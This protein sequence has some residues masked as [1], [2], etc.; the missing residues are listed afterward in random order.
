MRKRYL[1]IANLIYSGVRLS[2]GFSTSYRGCAGH[3][4]AFWFAAVTARTPMLWF[5]G[6]A[7]VDA[8]DGTS[9]AYA[10]K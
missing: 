5:L 4:L 9:I 3:I 2:A 8:L 10:N 1:G 7:N 6:N